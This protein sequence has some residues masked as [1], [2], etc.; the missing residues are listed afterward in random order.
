MS[1]TYEVW[2]LG[3][4]GKRP[5]RVYVEGLATRTSDPKRAEEKARE[6]LEQEG[7]SEVFVIKCEAVL[8]LK[9]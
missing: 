4:S 1:P 5:L 2:I 8:E 6:L 3:T 9:K 7:V